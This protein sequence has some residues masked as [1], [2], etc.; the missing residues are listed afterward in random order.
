LQSSNFSQS[1]VN[2]TK[3]DDERKPY[4]ILSIEGGGIRNILS[5][6]A[7]DYMET[8]ACKYVNEVK[9]TTLQCN[10]DGR[11][12]M[13]DMFD[14]IAGSSTGGVI[15]AALV[16]PANGHINQSYSSNEILDKF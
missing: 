7:L 3:P 12:L 1:I 8:Y 11:I 9:N 2:N 14:L 6:I 5:L 10:Q 13:K 15:A 4:N 16:C